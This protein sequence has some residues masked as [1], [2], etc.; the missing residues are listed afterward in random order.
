MVVAISFPRCTV[1]K[2]AF[3]FSKLSVDKYEFIKMENRAEGSRAS[4][5]IGLVQMGTME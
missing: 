3:M 4:C 5:V 1:V 2:R